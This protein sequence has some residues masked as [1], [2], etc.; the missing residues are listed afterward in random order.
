MQGWVDLGIGGGSKAQPVPKAARRS[1]NR[2]KHRRPRQDSNLGTFTPQADTL[3]ARPLQSA[4]IV[5]NCI[6]VYFC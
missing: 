2:D 6:I 5:N 3:T 4:S 1:N